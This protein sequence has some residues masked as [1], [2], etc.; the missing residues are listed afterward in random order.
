MPDMSDAQSRSDGELPTSRRWRLTAGLT[1]RSRMSRFQLFMTEMHPTARSRLIDVGV[2]DTAWRSGN[3]IE[4]NYP[5]P[6][7][8]T[9]VS[10]DPV[11]TFQRHHPDVN[12]VIADGRNLPFPDHSFEI[13]FSNA[14]IE[15]VGSRDE[16]RK[17]VAEM[18]RT[19]HNIREIVTPAYRDKARQALR[20]REQLY[21]LV[22]SAPSGVLQ[23]HLQDTVADLSAWTDQLLAVAKRL[24]SYARDSILQQDAAALPGQI[25]DLRQALAR[26]SD[27]ALRE[28]LRSA[29]EAKEVQ[30]ANLQALA[31]N[32]QEAELRLETTLTALGTV[33]TQVQLLAARRDAGGAAPRLSAD[34][35]EQVQRLQDV[36]AT[37]DQVYGTM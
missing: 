2:T 19:P 8:I 29:L 1:R 14:V 33:Y 26:E 23:D 16:Q 15:H 12:V 37:M 21:R 20:Y 28:Q 5:W 25:R 22:S 4:A 35:R 30:R 24:D 36:L 9:A 13:G 11:P 17:L 7:Q 31:K 34:I 27:P 10:I 3:F 6:S 32:M 18:L